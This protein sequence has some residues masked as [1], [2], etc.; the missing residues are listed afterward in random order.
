MQNPDATRVAGFRAWLKLGYVVRR[1]ETSLRIWV[2]MA[3]SKAAMADWEK[4]G[5][6]KDGKP[7]TFFKLGPVFDRSQIELL[8][9]PAE[10]MPLDLPIREVQ[11]EDLAPAFP[12]L[13]ALAAELGSSVELEEIP[14]G[15]MH[16]YYEPASKRIAISRALPENGRVK[17]LVHELAHA[18][19]RADHREEDPELDR[20]R[21]EL[22]A[23][24]V[25]LTVCSG[26]LGLD[27]SG[28]S[29]PYLTS[30]SETTGI[31]T[32]HHAAA[33]ID[34]LARRIED[35][36]HAAPLDDNADA[37]ADPERV[38]APAAV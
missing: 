14:G 31:E 32:I 10:P 23:E 33:L 16:G 5:R 6:P 24:T 1:G 22:V 3:P 11:G 25:A 26:A 21:E 29:V 35:A 20:A 2:P 17:T 28:Y 15:S 4:A 38:L 19:V 9:A 7:R 8:P 18:L 13:T 34:R 12:A 36:I 30:W 37:G 27:S